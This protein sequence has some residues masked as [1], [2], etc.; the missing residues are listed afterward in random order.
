MRGSWFFRLPR[1][2]F[3]CGKK[4]MRHFVWLLMAALMAAGSI[5]CRKI[6]CECRCHEYREDVLP[7][8]DTGDGTGGEP[9]TVKVTGF[10]IVLA[11]YPDGYDWL[12]DPDHGVVECDICLLQDGLE[13][14]R[15]P[16]GNEYMVSADIDMVRCIGEDVFTDFS[17]SSETIIRKNGEEILRYPG[18]EMVRG[19]AETDRKGIYTLGIPRDAAV[20]WT[21]RCSGEILSSSD[22]GEI[23][24][25]LYTDKEEPVFVY[26]SE[27][28][29]YFQVRGDSQTELDVPPA[30]GQ[31]VSV[32]FDRGTAEVCTLDETNILR[33]DGA[34]LAAFEDS[35]NI[36]AC[37][38]DGDTAGAVG[39]YGDDILSQFMY[40]DKEYTAFPEGYC[41]AAVSA[42]AFSDGHYCLCLNPVEPGLHPVCIMNG[43]TVELPV[44]GC[45]L[46][47]GVTVEYVVP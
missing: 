43:K 40:H 29:K 9:E 20:G 46:S 15:F 30:Y 22:T 5:S 24:S 44:N 31:V 35:F 8:N 18:R 38:P 23:V 11:E 10:N 28:G 47:L 3:L 39:Y 21:L 1:I 7:G 14:L 19:L 26:R 16:A 34:E 13:T 17:T 36:L 33:K 45:F 6:I 32:T 37:Y 27:E 12:R 2:V 4:S 42:G 41:L 25:A